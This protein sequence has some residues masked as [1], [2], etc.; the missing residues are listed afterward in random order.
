MRLSTRVWGITSYILHSK[1][2]YKIKLALD[3]ELTMC[4]AVAL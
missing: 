4:S 1:I 2:Y 3:H